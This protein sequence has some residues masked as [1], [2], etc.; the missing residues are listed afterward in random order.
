MGS[1]GRERN[2]FDP[3]SLGVFSVLLAQ[4]AGLYFPSI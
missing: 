4:P 3:G 1:F 2:G